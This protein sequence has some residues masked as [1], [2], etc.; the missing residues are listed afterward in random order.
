MGRGGHE[1]AW[2]AQPTRCCRTRGR[3]R[4]RRP[5]AARR[6]RGPPPSAARPLQ[7]GEE[8]ERTGAWAG[9][10]GPGSMANI[11]RVWAGVGVPSACGGFVATAARRC[12][13]CGQ[14]WVGLKKVAA[15]LHRRS[16]QLGGPGAC[17]KTPEVPPPP[18]T[19]TACTR[20]P[21]T[22]AP[23][24]PRPALAPAAVPGP[25]AEADRERAN[26]DDA[27]AEPVN[28][29]PESMGPRFWES[30]GCLHPSPHGSSRERFKPGTV[31]QVG[32]CWWRGGGNRTHGPGKNGS[33]SSWVWGQ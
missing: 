27:G 31:Q 24:R 10:G 3:T 20:L 23:P 29:V 11:G 21:P 19:A 32:S 12:A 4:R 26:D 7:H 2:T 33:S 25:A 15:P 1:E 28:M 17:G 6:G 14:V 18:A 9:V 16:E 8:A 13:V 22:C 30:E 5:C